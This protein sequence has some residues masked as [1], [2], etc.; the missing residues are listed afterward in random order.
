MSDKYVTTALEDGIA[1]ITLNDP[2]RM[3]AFAPRLI[4]ELH[5]AFSEIE[6]SDARCVVITGAGEAF[7]A[8]GDINQQLDLIESGKSL[9]ERV[10]STLEQEGNPLIEYVV[11]FPLPTIAKINGA[12]VGGGANLAIAC[13]IQL[14]TESASMGFV[15]QQVGLSV[16][17]GSSWL[18]PAMVGLNTA[19]ELVF[20]GK[21]ISAE[22]A[23]DIGL[24]NHVYPDDEFDERA[25]QVVTEI[26][27]GPTVALGHAK[28][29]LN[30]GHSAT[31]KEALQREALSQGIVF[32]TSDHEEGVQAFLKNRDPDFTGE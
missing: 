5:D 13:D 30:H 31:I 6:G 4:D 11:D 16:D 21:I 1:T 8:G 28:Q 26:A 22:E 15:F 29:A 9:D 25:A 17:M 10:R 23:E 18:L 3:N 24:V 12:A 20:R 19:K 7:S 32:D 14:A 2:E 27:E